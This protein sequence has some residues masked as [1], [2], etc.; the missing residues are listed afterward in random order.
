LFALGEAG[1]L[2]VRLLMAQALAVVGGLGTKDGLGLH[3]LLI[4]PALDFADYL[5]HRLSHRLSWLWR[6]RAVHHTDAAL[7]LTTTLR[8]HPIEVVVGQIVF[9]TVAFII[10]ASALEIAAYGVISFAVQLVAHA[11]VELPTA[12]ERVLGGV[13][14]TPSF[15]RF[16]HSRD[17]RQADA[18]Y[19]QVLS[20]WDRVFG[21]LA[22][23]D[24]R[25]TPAAFGVD[26][27]AAPRF[28]TVA[29]MLLQPMLSAK[30]RGSRA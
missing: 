16:H 6:L 15:H 11:N 21:T 25:E 22:P 5:L 27:F 7:D 3:A 12:F 8:H 26:A 24:G 23:R 9:L 1:W 10:G 17:Q 30:R 13:L 29:G 18:N 4:I 14:V 19:G 28:G 20:L 2:L